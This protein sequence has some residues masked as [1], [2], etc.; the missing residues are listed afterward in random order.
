MPFIVWS[1][2][3]LIGDVEI[4]ADHK[5]AADLVNRAY[6]HMVEHPGDKFGLSDLTQELTAHTQR[7]FAR[8]EEMMAR[9]ACPLLEMHREEHALFLVKAE[10]KWSECDEGKPGSHEAFFVLVRDWFAQHVAG[11][12]RKA[13]PYFARYREMESRRSAR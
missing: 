4:D 2:A 3:I 1:D 5:I 7:H 8:E 13:A 11:L 12:D 6:D 10:R 9:T